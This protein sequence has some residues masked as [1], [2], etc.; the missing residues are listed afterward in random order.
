ME[1]ELRKQVELLEKEV[2]VL[3]EID[4]VNRSFL[5]DQQALIEIQRIQIELLTEN[6]SKP[7][8]DWS[9]LMYPIVVLIGISAMIFIAT[10]KN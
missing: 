10:L 7:K 1:Q 9:W 2:S 5:K 3:K 4:K 6:A 8:Q